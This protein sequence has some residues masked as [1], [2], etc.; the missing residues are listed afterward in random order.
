MGMTLHRWAQSPE[1]IDEARRTMASPLFG[2]IF[3]VMYNAM[4]HG[5]PLR[6]Q[7]ATDIGVAIELGRKEGYADCLSLLRSLGHIL[8]APE[9]IPM[10][11]GAGP[12]PQR[13]L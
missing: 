7:P 5:Y 4:P 11:F 12:P 8:P 6:G 3:S 2:H 1:L 13:E 9:E 10:D